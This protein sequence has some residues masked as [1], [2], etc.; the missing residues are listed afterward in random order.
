[1][2]AAAES[3]LIENEG[4]EWAHSWKT[5]YPDIASQFIKG[6]DKSN[7]I[8]KSE[9]DL[10]ELCPGDEI[11]DFEILRFVGAGAFGRVY[12]ANDKSLDRQCALKVTVDQG[13]EGKV[14]A[15]L[16]HPGIVNVFREHRLR[17]KKFLAMQFVD[18]MSLAEWIAARNSTE[19]VTERVRTGVR[20]IRD[21]AGALQHAHVRGILHRDIKPANILIDRSG[22]TLL[23][24][25]NVATA[26][27]QDG[28]FQAGG[29]INY[30]SPEQL[31]AVCLN[32]VA[33]E[34]RI[35]IRSDV[36]SLGVV[37]LEI[38]TGQKVWD[39]TTGKDQHSATN[40]LLATR[41][42]LGSTVSHWTARS[43][44]ITGVNRQ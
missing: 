25:F 16:S 26:A 6:F 3:W 15:K 14:L 19:D 34:Y 17:G 12:L 31:Q 41:L 35:D 42:P 11:L 40:Q 44:A 36:Y 18:G 24:D 32:D 30:M 9:L 43:H 39:V 20:W 22:H 37:L 21:V 8:S 13:S 5:D 29:T 33:A 1:M 2:L 28:R 10:D 38:L 7:D 4:A 27:E 23:G